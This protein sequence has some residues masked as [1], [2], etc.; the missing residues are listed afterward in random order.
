MQRI[1]K[2][3]PGKR[4]TKKPKYHTMNIAQIKL[5]E[6]LLRQETEDP[7]TFR[8]LK[9]DIKKHGVLCPILIDQDSLLVSGS[10]RLR[11]ASELKL[12]RIPYIR[13][14][15]EV[16]TDTVALTSNLTQI[17]VSELDIAR[18]VARI[19]KTEKYTQR[20]LAT[21]Y[22]VSQT[23]IF[24]WA[25][26]AS[27]PEHIKAYIRQRRFSP[28]TA[29]EWAKADP[30]IRR[31]LEQ[32]AMKGLRVACR[33]AL[34]RSKFTCLSPSLMLPGSEGLVAD[35]GVQIK[36]NVPLPIGYKGGK[37]NCPPG[38]DPEAWKSFFWP[39]IEEARKRH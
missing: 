22:G 7:E 30:A 39:A 9:A 20:Q 21:K 6:V 16:D 23:K 8:A 2:T 38:I 14:G 13:L 29:I 19:L 26:L 12:K 34:P 32:K 15:P 18:W 36:I 35:E 27:V 10:R 31:R 17:D 3:P 37:N 4:Q 5:P 25:T 24:R 11:A 1:E 33:E 28:R